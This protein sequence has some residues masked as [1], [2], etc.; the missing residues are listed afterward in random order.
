MTSDRRRVLVTSDRE[1]ATY[2]L[3]AADL[4]VVGRHPAGGVAVALGADDRT[5]AL[6][7]AHGGVRLLDR[8]TSRVRP[9]GAGGAGA[10]TRM[11]FTPDGATLAGV[12]ARG[13]LILW[14]VG[15]GRVKERFDAH[16]GS[17]EA[18]AVT[19]DGQT[20]I[21]SGIDGRVAL[22]NVAGSRLLQHVP[23]R[24]R[25]ELGDDFTPRG[26][27][28][29]PD[30]KTLAVTQ[31]DGTVDLIDSAT[32]RRRDVLR[33]G[34]GPALAV[35]FSPDGRLLAVTGDGGRVGLWDAH[36]LTPVARLSGLR[37]WTQAVAFSPDGR[38]VAAGD[39]NNER[40][41]L[42]VWDVAS[43]TP[44]SVRAYLPVN[45]LTFSPDG[46]LLAV[47]AMDRG[48][49]VRDPRSG[50]LVAHLRT[51]ELA[52][53]VAFSPN[54][55]LLFVGL[56]NG[57]GQFYATRDWRPVGGRIRGQDQRLLNARFSPDGQTLATSSADGTV[58]LWDVAT[59]KPI[60]SP[61]PVER[62]SYVAA[63]MSGDG[64]LFA[65]SAGKEGIRLALSPSTWKQQACTI[66]G[67]ELTTREWADALPGRGYRRV[68]GCAPR[69]RREIYRVPPERRPHSYR[70]AGRCLHRPQPAV[71]TD[72]SGD[73]LQATD[74][75]F[76]GDRRVRVARRRARPPG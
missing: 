74:G 68:C 70:A 54:G 60:G 56:L 27:A 19:P 42:R 21:T 6:A 50:R 12:T 39:T 1:D 52:R 22:W 35:A 26:V 3:D 17:S 59:R 10:I 5:V 23:L 48:V 58:M 53:S 57:V 8:R 33:T 29:S 13:K 75:H 71:A 28:L 34:A 61:V 30:D 9:L 44:T 51:D 31:S 36:T 41:G 63:V 16:A 32:L 49:S 40:V 15:A 25:F 47:A 37:S 2:E 66:A 20:A 55:R 64:H 11:A 7:D 45:A 72:R 4:R 46:R 43:H 69:R 62:D 67:R 38:L 24:R 18:V 65:L 76:T 73:V 14:D